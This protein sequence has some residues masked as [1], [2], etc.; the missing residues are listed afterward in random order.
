MPSFVTDDY[1]RRALEIIQDKVAK[2]LRISGRQF[3]WSWNWQ[4]ELS[5][6]KDVGFLLPRH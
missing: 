3:N 1:C 6:P 2:I 4:S 5:T